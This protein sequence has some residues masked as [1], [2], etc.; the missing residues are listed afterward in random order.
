MPDPLLEGLPRPFH[1]FAS[2][3]DE[4]RD[5]PAPWRVLARSEACAVQVMR[6]GE[7]PVWGIQPH[8]EMTI[9]DARLLLQGILRAT[10]ERE[11]LVK[12]AF[13]QVPQ[14]DDVARRLV[15]NFLAVGAG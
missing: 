15:E 9:A 10:P 5:P 11:A 7:A 13:A 14:D 4:V 3:F 6:F 1:V 12:T 2:H 8:P